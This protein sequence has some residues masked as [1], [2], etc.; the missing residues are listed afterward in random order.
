MTQPD[1]IASTAVPEPPPVLPAHDLAPGMW[2]WGLLFAAVLVFEVWAIWTGRYTLSETVWL[3]PKWFRWAL[4]LGFLYL[5][6]HLFL[7]R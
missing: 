2:F 7:E 4:G 5:L 3:G 1:C 6:Y